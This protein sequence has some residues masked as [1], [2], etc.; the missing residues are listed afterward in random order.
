MPDVPSVLNGRAS[1]SPKLDA[2]LAK[3]KAAFP[4]IELWMEPGRF[5]VASAGVLIARVTQLKS[6]GI[7]LR[8]HRDRNEL[9]DPSGALWCI[10]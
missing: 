10:P 6:K 8:G 3:V 2:A 7:T 4:Q 1:T 9:A 5:F